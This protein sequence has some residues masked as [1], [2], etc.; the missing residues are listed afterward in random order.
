MVSAYSATLERKITEIFEH[1]EA[2]PKR[3]LKVVQ[4]EIEVRGKKVLPG[5]LLQLRIVRALTLEESNRITE[6]R[7]E[8]FGVLEEM[9]KSATVDHY[10]LDTFIKTTQRMKDKNLY[11]QEYF[12]LIEILH[13]KN[14]K[15][16]ELTHSLY[17]GSL[18]NGNFAT[19]AKM[20]SKMV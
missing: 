4:K 6:S 8:V 18:V 17:T 20:A 12:K 7:D 5:E 15:D 1:L 3:A 19:A 2:D 9:K 13:A 14:P 11:Q 16:K 10:V